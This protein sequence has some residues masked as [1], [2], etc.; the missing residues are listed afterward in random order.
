MTMGLAVALRRG[1]ADQNGLGL[2]LAE[3]Y[4]NLLGGGEQRRAG[5]IREGP[6]LPA[7][8]LSNGP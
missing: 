7:L 5:E 8:R 2:A 6:G 4:L 1:S 3:D